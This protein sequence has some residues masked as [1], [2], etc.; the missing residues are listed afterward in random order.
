MDKKDFYFELPHE[1]IAQTPLVDRSASRMMVVNKTIGSIQD[2]NFTEIIDYLHEGDVLVRNDSRV[3]PARLIGTKEIT[4]AHVELLLLRQ[5]GDVWECLVGNAKVIKLDT[6]VS[7]GDGRLKAKCVKVKDG[8]LRDFL[9]IYKGMFYAILDSLGQVPLPPYITEKLADGERY[10]TVYAK[11]LGSSAAPTAGLHFTKTI[12]DQLKAKGVKIVD[13]TLHVGLGTFKPLSEDDVLEHKMHEEYYMMSQETADIL[14]LAKR[15][16]RRIISVGT[17]STRTLETIIAK[18][19]TF[20]VS[21]G[22][23]DIYIYPGYEFKAI[24]AL[25]TNFH[26]PE[27]TLILLVSALA[28]KDLILSSYQHAIK[29]RY[30][31]FS[32]GDAMF[33]Y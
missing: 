24:D 10:Q 17:T 2:H 26:L 19:G 32:F 31:F 33:I 8:G 15:E 7:F 5:T 20:C 14:N 27:S 13:I 12:F 22:M 3:I 23:T 18:Y 25:I 11:V 9:M 29:E 1:L 30:R 16:K 28:G 4:N 6:I 21:S